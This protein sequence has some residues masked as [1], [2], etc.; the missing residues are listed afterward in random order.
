MRILAVSNTYPPE[1]I[2]GAERLT[3]ALCASLAARGHTV[4][5]LTA[6][7]PPCGNGVRETQRGAGI[8]RVWPGGR[9]F[10]PAGAGPGARLRVQL[11]A[12]ALDLWNPR[13]AGALRRLA[14]TARPDVVHTHN[15]YGF[16]PAVWSAARRLGLPVVHTAHDAWLL[17]PRHN[18]LYAPFP[19]G[20]ADGPLRRLYARLYAPRTR[21][22]D[23][24][25][26][27]SESHLRLHLALGCRPRAGGVCIPHGLPP[28]TAPAPER[29]PGRPVTFLYLG[30]LDAHKGLGVLDA[31][32]RR[33]DGAPPLRLEIAGEGPRRA[34]AER[35]AA[36]DPRVACRGF[37]DGP[38]RDAL[39]QRADVLLYPS[40]CLESFGLAVLEAMAAGCTAVVSAAGGQAERIADGRT[41]L[42]VPPGDP[43]ALAERIASLADDR[44]RLAA[45]QTAAR[46]AARAAS[47]EAMVDA[48]EA[49]YARA[50]GGGACHQAGQLM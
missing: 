1:V 46:A 24:L 37:V 26:T 16:S 42:T 47:W 4:A 38:A 28:D 19:P 36:R 32:F 20:F 39:L 22:V 12:H 25:C 10:P 3:A 15:L 11:R 9:L 43:A 13:A 48:Y 31:A 17:H 18:L 45:L 21:A 35:L 29:P 30:R 44:D 23:I 5:V 34:A 41:G 50:A 6:G 7:P 2:G 8:T 40:L 49:L 14:Q 33:L 27:P